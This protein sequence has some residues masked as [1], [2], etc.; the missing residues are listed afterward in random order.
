MRVTWGP[1]YGRKMPW[2]GGGLLLYVVLLVTLGVLTF[3]RGHFVLFAI[4]FV[5]P[6]CWLIGSLVA[7]RPGHGSGRPQHAGTHPEHHGRVTINPD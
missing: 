4:G 2:I 1:V 5:F 7:P 3:R 6:L